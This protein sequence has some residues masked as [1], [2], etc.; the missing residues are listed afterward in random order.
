MIAAALLCAFGFAAGFLLIRRVPLCPSTR[1]YHEIYFSI[2][3]PARNE[4]QIYRVCLH[5]S[6][7]LPRDLWKSS[8]SMMRRPTTL[9]QLRRAWALAC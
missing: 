9:R 7:L 5:P 6:L 2:V 8:L 3:I 4:E 1:S